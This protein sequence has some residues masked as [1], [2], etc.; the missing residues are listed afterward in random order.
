VAGSSALHHRDKHSQT[1]QE[2]ERSEVD[3]IEYDLHCKSAFFLRLMS[4]GQKLEHET[5]CCPA[6]LSFLVQARDSLN[7]RAVPATGNSISFTIRVMTR[8]LGPDDPGKQRHF[9]YIIEDAPLDRAAAAL[10]SF[11]TN[12]IKWFIGILIATV[13]LSTYVACG[14][15]LLDTRDAVNRDAGANRAAIM[16]TSGGSILPNTPSED[17]IE[18]YCRSNR[19]GAA[20]SPGV[21]GNSSEVSKIQPCAEYVEILRRNAAINNLLKGWT[22]PFLQGAG[23]RDD[24]DA[25]V[26]DIDDQKVAQWAATWVGLLGNYL[27]PV[28]YGTLGSFGFVLRR[29]N[30]Q[31][32]DYLLTPRMLRANRIRI[33]LGVMTGACIGLFINTSAGSATTSG[34]GGAAVTLTAS[35]L[36]FLAGYGVE[37]VFKMFDAL[38]NHIFNVDDRPTRGTPA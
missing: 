30:R 21:P 36:A 38:M 33:L 8:L 23:R 4:I 13:L 15:L 32:A 18:N 20:G 14:K 34:L 25:L 3:S 5:A 12:N 7:K 16:A 1:E 22:W 35:G 11:V 27:L 10:A 28:L 17:W 9:S 26:R 37:A 29:L 19:S 2:E 6:E 24:E 31:L